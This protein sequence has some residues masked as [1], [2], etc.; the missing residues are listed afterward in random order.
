MITINENPAAS[1]RGGDFYEMNR[2]W[3]SGDA[4]RIKFPVRWRIVEGRKWQSGTCAILRGPVVYCLNPDHN[5]DLKNISPQLY[6]RIV[7]NPDT[8]KVAESKIMDG[9]VYHA[10]V[11]EGWRPGSIQDRSLK[12]SRK[13]GQNQ[14]NLILTEFADPGGVRTFFR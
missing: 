7:I 10:G 11:V 12:P 2:V 9:I 13:G 4:I 5:P 14:L 6:H 1:V 3:K 8:L